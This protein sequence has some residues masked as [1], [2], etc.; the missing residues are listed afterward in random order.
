MSGEA[1]RVRVTLDFD[2]L[3][4]RFLRRIAATR[5]SRSGYGGLVTDHQDGDLG[6]L[7]YQAVLGSNPDDGY[8]ELGLELVGYE[9]SETGGKA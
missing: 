4:E 5:M 7:V 8:N 1:K 9:T 2:V 3:D 6:E